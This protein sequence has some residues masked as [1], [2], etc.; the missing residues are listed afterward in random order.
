[1][2]R[3]I[4][5]SIKEKNNGPLAGRVEKISI[6]VDTILFFKPYMQGVHKIGLKPEYD[7][8]IIRDL[9]ISGEIESITAEDH[10]I[11][12]LKE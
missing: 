5:I 1:M 2:S 11:K 7:K 9:E 8:K 3:F 4:S 10:E 6:S 12:S